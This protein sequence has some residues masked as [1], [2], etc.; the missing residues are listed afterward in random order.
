MIDPVLERINWQAPGLAVGK[1]VYRR[2]D[3]GRW[4]VTVTGDG[5][6]GL[7]RQDEPDPASPLSPPPRSRTTRKW[8]PRPTGRSTASA[9]W[10][11]SSGSC[12]AA[13]DRV[14]IQST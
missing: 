2:L 12:P 4:V 6:L 5:S 1:A 11:S 10:M 3:E 13:G 7:A 8:K 14:R 9:P